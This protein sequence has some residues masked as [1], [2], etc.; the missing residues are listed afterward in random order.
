MGVNGCDFPFPGGRGLKGDE[1]S[2]FLRA[3]KFD[4]EIKQIIFTTR[5]VCLIKPGTMSLDYI[6]SFSFEY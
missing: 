1:V 4:C 5:S 2:N 3:I 6:N